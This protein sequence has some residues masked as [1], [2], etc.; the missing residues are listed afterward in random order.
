MLNNLFLKEKHFIHMKYVS[1][2]HLG[3]FSNNMLYV[4]IKSIK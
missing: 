2:N 4:K 1:Y 3:Y